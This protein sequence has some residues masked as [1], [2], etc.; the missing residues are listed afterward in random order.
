MI[1][2]IIPV[3]NEAKTLPEFLSR[4]DVLVT[5][6]EVIIVDGQSLDETMALASKHTR[7]DVIVTQSGRGRARQMN[8]GAAL[9][10]GDI[11]LFLHADTILP[12]GALADIEKALVDPDVIGGRFRV[13][14]DNKRMP[15]RL[16]GAMINIRDAMFGGFTGDQA[17]FVR[18]K[19]FMALGGFNEIEICED[20][21]LAARMQKAGKV[22]QLPAKVITSARRWE[23]DGWVRTI[24]LMWIIRI[25][26][27]LR[28]SPKS[29][30]QLYADTR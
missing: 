10:H 1:S 26:F 16:I 7:A 3:F 20:L 14:L 2:I 8:S 30:S 27:Y 22:V 17:I 12:L 28:I 6:G 21:D 19:D 11:L 4:L 23:K 18:K 29:I 9:A 24:I 5:D 13:E 25:M 15:Y